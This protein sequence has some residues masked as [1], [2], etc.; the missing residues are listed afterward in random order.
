MIV[1][2]LIVVCAAAAVAALAFFAWRCYQAL[3]L[4][5]LAQTDAPSD[6]VRLVGRSMPALL[7]FTT[8]D[9]AQCRFRQSPILQQFARGGGPPVVT[10]DAIAEAGV[11]RHFGVMTVPTTVLLD[12]A[13]RPV[14]IN[15]GLATLER[16]QQQAG[17]LSQ[18]Q[19]A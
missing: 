3:C 1:E 4:Q 11:A 9:C 17:A 15:H 7:Y 2:R 18:P 8:D 16:L 5:K 14:A 12:A 13:L 19:P 10:V 6:L